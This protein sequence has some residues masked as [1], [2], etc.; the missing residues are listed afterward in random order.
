MQHILRS[1]DVS[2]QQATSHVATK[3][4][5]TAGMLFDLLEQRKNI[6][7]RDELLDLAKRYDM[8]VD[9]LE[10]VATF[11]NTPSTVADSLRKI[12]EDDGRE[13]ITTL[14]R[15]DNPDVAFFNSHNSFF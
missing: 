8:E 10:R 4:R 5:M 2:E 9:V 15:G 1:R 14:V 12:L 6:S 13:R 11:V 7:S 3:N